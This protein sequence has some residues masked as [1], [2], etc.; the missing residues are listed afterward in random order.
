MIPKINN[1]A[2]PIIMNNAS[3]NIAKKVM[4]PV[5]GLT[6]LTV[7]SGAWPGP[8]TPPPDAHFPK[9]SVDDGIFES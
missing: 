1:I 7:L 6:G 2:K 5:A 4:V 3:H 9:D 8:S